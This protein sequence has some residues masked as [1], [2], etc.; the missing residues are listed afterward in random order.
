MSATPR[1]STACSPTAIT[2]AAPSASGDSVASRARHASSTGMVPVVDAGGGSTSPSAIASASA[3]S[4][5]GLPPLS[6]ARRAI[7][8]RSVKPGETRVAS[9]LASR[10]SSGKP[11]CTGTCEKVVP[12]SV[13]VATLTEPRFKLATYRL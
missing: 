13:D 10:S 3:V 7:V 6:S 5:S 11:A 9:S 2:T 8:R 4:V 12:L 1:F